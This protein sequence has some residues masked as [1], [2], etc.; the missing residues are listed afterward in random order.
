[1]S[2]YQSIFDSKNTFRRDVWHEKRWLG[3]WHFAEGQNADHVARSILE[4]Q[5]GPG[6]VKGVIVGDRESKQ[7]R[8]W[9]SFGIEKPHDLT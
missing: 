1:M 8:M 7:P 2:A 5:F 3:F 4:T 9:E 6:N